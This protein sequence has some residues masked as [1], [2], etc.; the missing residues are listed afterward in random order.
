M[1]SLN[2][3][4]PLMSLIGLLL[5]GAASVF[6]SHYFANHQAQAQGFF[7]RTD[8]LALMQPV[9]LAADT[10]LETDQSSA[11]SSGLVTTNPGVLTTATAATKSASTSN[12][13]QLQ[14]SATSETVRIPLYNAQAVPTQF[15][16][17]RMHD[18][19]ARIRFQ[20]RAL[21][22][23]GRVVSTIP[24][25]LVPQMGRISCATPGHALTLFSPHP[26][27]NDAHCYGDYSMQITSPV[28]TLELTFTC[29]VASKLQQ[30]P[31]TTRNHIHVNSIT[32][33]SQSL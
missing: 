17:L 1:K 31:K 28:A 32:Y 4:L 22:E 2:H 29:P 33:L 15:I 30:C 12:E 13:T 24:E 21:D 25:A 8:Q 6:P 19:G 16:T 3:H 10:T 5:L 26:H 9:P 23:Q 27:P 18:H 11:S 7:L 14:A 20:V